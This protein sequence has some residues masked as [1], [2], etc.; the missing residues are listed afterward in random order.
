MRKAFLLAFALTSPA[1]FAAPCTMMLPF[2]P[3]ALALH[4]TASG[5]LHLHY[6]LEY[7]GYVPRFGAPAVS[8]ADDRIVVTQPVTDLADA[9]DPHQ[10]ATPTNICYA[11]DVDLPPLGKGIYWVTIINPL[12]VPDPAAAARFGTAG[13]IVGD[14]L[15]VQCTTTRVLATSPVTPVAGANVTLTST[16]MTA[17]TY[18]RTEVVRNGNSFVMVDDTT[19]DAPVAYIPYCLTSSAELGP[20]PAGTYSVTWAVNDYG[21]IRWDRDAL[22]SLTISAWARHRAAR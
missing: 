22:F 7:L 15:N 20:L 10:F 13:F 5:S 19:S 3:P 14:D 11:D 12:I 16:V 9:Y 8:F 4:R 18:Q 1:A 17:G 6:E 21:S 2:S